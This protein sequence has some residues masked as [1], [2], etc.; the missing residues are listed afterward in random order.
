MGYMHGIIGY[1]FYVTLRA[2]YNGSS[3]S[4]CYLTT[5][6]LCS[7]KQHIQLLKQVREFFWILNLD[8]IKNLTKV[9]VQLIEPVLP[10]LEANTTE[11]TD[12]VLVE[13]EE[14]HLSL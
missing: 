1:Y 3:V 9:E 5:T 2:C 6:A 7:A 10:I 8:L 11:D 14:G 4:Y 13:Q 12:F